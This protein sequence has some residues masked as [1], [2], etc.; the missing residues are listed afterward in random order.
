MYSFSFVWCIAVSSPVLRV[1]LPH[2]CLPWEAFCV[3]EMCEAVQ[4]LY[5][6]LCFT[7][8]LYID[9]DLILFSVQSVA[10]Y[11]YYSSTYISKCHT[12]FYHMYSF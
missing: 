8:C 2:S 12:N 6:R 5:V 3:L 11:Q 9:S 10:N 4:S 7:V 1:T